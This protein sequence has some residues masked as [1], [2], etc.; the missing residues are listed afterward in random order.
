MTNRESEAGKLKLI[1]DF[2]HT[3]LK[4][5]TINILRNRMFGGAPP[6]HGIADTPCLKDHAYDYYALFHRI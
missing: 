5:R 3:N 6:R 4:T 1:R 2:V